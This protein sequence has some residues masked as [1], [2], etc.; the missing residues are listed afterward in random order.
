MITEIENLTIDHIKP[1]SKGGGKSMRNLQTLCLNCNQEKGNNQINYR[2]NS[3]KEDLYKQLSKN[4]LGE[5]SDQKNQD[6]YY[7]QCVNKK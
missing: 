2:K 4:K 3:S 1:L 5:I 7:N 6:L